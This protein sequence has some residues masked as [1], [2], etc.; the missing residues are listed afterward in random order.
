MKL[1]KE[2]QYS[3]LLDISYLSDENIKN[4]SLENKS[5]DSIIKIQVINKNQ[6]R[7]KVH[8]HCGHI[9]IGNLSYF[10]VPKLGNDFLHTMLAAFNRPFF[11]E[12]NND[13]DTSKTTTL[14]DEI[15]AYLFIGSY[16]RNLS[17]KIRSGYISERITT[18]KSSGKVIID[19]SKEFFQYQSKAPTWEKSLWS[20]NTKINKAIRTL[21]LSLARNLDVS[22][23]TKSKLSEIANEVCDTEYRGHLDYY[24]LMHELDRLHQPYKP[25]LELAINLNAAESAK[26]GT[27]RNFSLLIPTWL[28]FEGACKNAIASFNN[29]HKVNINESFTIPIS[30]IARNIL[31]PDI[32]I[33]SKENTV[34]AIGDCKYTENDDL[35]LK[36]DHMFQVNTYMDGYKLNESF[37]LYPTKNEFKKKE[38]PLNW[39][40]SIKI[41]TIPTSNI[42][43]FINSLKQVLSLNT[44]PDLNIAV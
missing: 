16:I 41:Y 40:S 39:G 8:N 32:V 3:D 31:D 24:A 11:K 43:D 1:L 38:F 14:F 29:N 44:K 22:I 10:I 30:D 6:F 12:F 34:L 5:E 42:E 33:K 4:L 7:F 9:K 25:I 2:N 35:K 28:L 19:D 27:N 37:I 21:F 13:L 20:R 17:G 18:Y 36:R 23:K 15:I 26:S